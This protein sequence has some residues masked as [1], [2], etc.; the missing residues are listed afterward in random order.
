[1]AVLTT[2]AASSIAQTTAVSGGTITYQGSNAITAR[3]VCWSTSP[4][5]TIA[6]SFTSNGTGTGTFTSNL[7]GL[8]GGTT[9]YIRA[10]AT[11]ASGTSYGNQ[12]SFLTTNPQPA[13]PTGSVFCTGT[14]TLV[15]DVTNPSTGKTWMDRNLGATQVATNSIDVNAYGDYYQWGRRG[16]GHQCNN[17]PT[18]T[19][20]SSVDQ[21]AHGNFITI[22]SGN[23]DWR[24]P[25]NVNLWQGVNGI[26]NPC[27][28]GY[29]LPT[30]TELN[31]ELLTWTSSNSVG[32]F[33]S[34]LK[35]PLAGYRDGSFGAL[36]EIGT[37]GRY[38]SST[39]SFI[40]S[41]R[42]LFDGGSASIATNFRHNALPIRCIKN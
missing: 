7:T 11:N 31:N 17:S 4:N 41:V 1:M 19:N 22:N 25:Q 37:K 24:S 13:Y 16:D 10:Y 12:V 42:L 20:L 2:T 34:I 9:Y 36:V 27:P 38:Y 29:R 30:E 8:T 32:A 3:G 18:T 26:N 15:I 6:N 28:N 35:L 14:P 5:P 33:N 39:V 23:Y 40:S 21:P